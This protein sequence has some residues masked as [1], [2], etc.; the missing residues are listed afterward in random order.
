MRVL[1]TGGAGFIGSHLVRE[2]LRRG[3]SVRVIDNLSTGKRSNLSDI[4]KDIE[5]VE[6]D[7]Q[8]YPLLQRTM[9]GV[10]VVFHQAALPSVPRSIQDPIT[11][12]LVNVV[13]TTTVL[14]A[15]VDAG[16]RRVV[17]AASSS[18]YG[19]VPELLKTETMF[20]RP[21]SPYAVTK[22]AGEYMLQAFASCYG[23]ETVG[24]RYFNVFGERQDPTS[25][26][27]GV[28]AKF[29]AMMLRHERPT[30]YG[31]GATS[32]DFTYVQNV[33]EANFLA[34]SA[35]KD[36]VNGRVINVACGRSITLNQLV[37]ELNRVLG[38]D[39]Q[40]IYGPE[41]PGDVRHSCADIRLARE[42][43]GYEPKI[44]FDVGLEKT[45]EWYRSHGNW[46]LFNS[47]Q[48]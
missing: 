6:G 47:E 18:A 5:F 31:D 44:S 42:L 20:P 11:S 9:R 37:D 48:H 2:A 12:T 32:R 15:A 14:K 45:V 28:I 17:Y 7:I 38:T 1:I 33:V 22:L 43:I 41:R 40:P 3:Y 10:E 39:L 21:L 30:I 35:P 34:M 46:E 16:V 23:L 36:K 24:L 8:N 19:N 13:G 4:E 29:T 27:S 25:Q 26:Y